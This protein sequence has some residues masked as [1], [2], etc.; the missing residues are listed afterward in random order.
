ML[1]VE[2]NHVF[3]KTKE[4]LK[5]EFGKKFKFKGCGLYLTDN[6]TMLITNVFDSFGL[7][8]YWNMNGESFRAYVWDCNIDQNILQF[9]K[10]IPIR[11]D[12]RKGR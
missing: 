12:K 11:V 2:Y 9:A 8:E 10:D 1:I 6:D 5:L 3:H 4:G 7:T